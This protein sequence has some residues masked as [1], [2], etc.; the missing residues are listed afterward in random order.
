[1]G[2][3]GN[4]K[5]RWTKKERS[6]LGQR[7]LEDRDVTQAQTNY[8]LSGR[9]IRI[10]F[11]IILICTHKNCISFLEAHDSMSNEKNPHTLDPKS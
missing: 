6:T 11:E 3:D 1:M 7:T 9:F 2:C 4:W 10:I 8:K 5:E